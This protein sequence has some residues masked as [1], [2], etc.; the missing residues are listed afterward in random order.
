MT[1][2][3]VSIPNAGTIGDVRNLSLLVA[4]LLLGCSDDAPAP[5]PADSGAV[6]DSVVADVAPSCVPES[7][8]PPHAR[9]AKCSTMELGQMYDTCLG[10]SATTATCNTFRTAHLGC[11]SCFLTDANAADQGALTQWEQTAVRLID[12]NTGGCLSLLAGD[13]SATSCGAK[14]DAWNRCAIAQCCTTTPFATFQSC[15][16]AARTGACKD[17]KTTYD[18]CLPGV[19]DGKKCTPAG[20]SSALDLYLYLGKLF[21]TTT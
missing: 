11:Y 7:F 14:W 9:E 18:A 12:V 19:V 15:V 6:V 17:L 1:E 10:P 21:C 4:S 16:A 5:A 20:Q 3:S 2:C 13:S 8:H